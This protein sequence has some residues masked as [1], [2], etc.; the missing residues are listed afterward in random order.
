MG[1]LKDTP[2]DQQQEMVP[3]LEVLFGKKPVIRGLTVEEQEEFV[4]EYDKL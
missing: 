2:P 4:R 3:F 1:E